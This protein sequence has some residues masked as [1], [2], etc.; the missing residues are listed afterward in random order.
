MTSYPEIFDKHGNIAADI[1]PAAVETM[2]DR[3][4]EVLVATLKDARAAEAA[5]AHRIECRTAVNVAMKAHDAALADDTVKNPPVSFQ[6]AQLAVINRDNPNYQ[7][8]KRRVNAKA[9][10]A[11]ATAITTLAEARADL[12]RAEAAFKI[13]DTARSVAVQRWIDA[14]PRVTQES[15]HREMVAADRAAKLARVAKG[16]PAVPVKVEPVRPSELDR[17]LA[18]RGK[19]ANRLPQYHGKR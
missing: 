2:D 13:A 8:P 15:V 19:V 16:E 10:T 4:R 12:N 5:D 1:D 9:R 17:V 18:S 14:L 11:L 7:P 3:L 6:E